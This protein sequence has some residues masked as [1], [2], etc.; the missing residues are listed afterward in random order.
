MKKLLVILSAIACLFFL[1]Y[2]GSM[3]W[4]LYPHTNLQPL[5]P[6]LIALNSDEG[7]QRLHNAE[8]A[9]DYQRLSNTFQ[10]Q[11]LISYCGVASSVSVL[12][13]LGINTSQWWFFN[14]QTKKI[15]SQKQVMFG[16]MSLSEL[17]GL[18]MAHGAKSSVRHGGDID[19]AEFRALVEQNLANDNDYLLINY[20]RAVLGQPKLGHISPIAAYDRDTDSVLI[21]D[22]AA[23]K[24]PF[25]WVP[26]NTLHS[27]MNTID[28]S[29][30]KARGLV[31][32]S[33]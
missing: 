20:Q 22:T 31:E 2:G 24:Y 9:A 1:G 29:S 15:R 12:N 4:S 23:H 5:P 21:I 10:A 19:I 26:L 11:K 27:A 16:G 28:S 7:I 8:A 33:L 6:S 30:G 25:T 13:A 14:D 18:L 3:A 32:V 17:A